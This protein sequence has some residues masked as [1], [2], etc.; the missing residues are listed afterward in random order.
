MRIVPLPMPRTGR[1]HLANERISGAN[2]MNSHALIITLRRRRS[3]LLKA[4]V[5]HVGCFM[6]TCAL[7]ATDSVHATVASSLWMVLVTIPPVLLYTALVDRSCR[8][9]DPAAATIGWLKIVLFTLF[10]T[11]IESSVVLPARNLWVSGR[12]LRSYGPPRRS[13][14]GRRSIIARLRSARPKG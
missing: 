5:F 9:I 7:A 8:R 3:L 13:P 12:I 2:T 6:S 4:Y 14:P 1:W 11:P 10:L